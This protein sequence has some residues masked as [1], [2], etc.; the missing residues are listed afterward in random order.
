MLGEEHNTLDKVLATWEGHFT[1]IELDGEVILNFRGY[2]VLSFTLEL[3][4]DEQN[5]VDLLKYM[6][7]LWHGYSIGRKEINETF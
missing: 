3:K 4:D 2:E 6:A 1:Y 7:G 5:L